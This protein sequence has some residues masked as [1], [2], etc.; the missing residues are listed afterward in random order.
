MHRFDL[1]VPVMNTSNEK[2]INFI[3]VVSDFFHLFYF[4]IEIVLDREPT[5]W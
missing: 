2:N 4:Q 1:T 5:P 3:K